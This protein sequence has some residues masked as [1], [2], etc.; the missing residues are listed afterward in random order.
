MALQ[1]IFMLLCAIPT[2]RR[3]NDAFKSSQLLARCVLVIRGRGNSVRG[4]A[5]AK[6]EHRRRWIPA[7]PHRVM[8]GF[9][10]RPNAAEDH[11]G[12]HVLRTES[13][14]HDR[15]EDGTS[16]LSTTEPNR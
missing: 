13:R 16:A 1:L 3:R 14:V 4:D 8:G 12:G 10:L 7:S 9:L 5:I 15:D 6:A 11:T 2:L